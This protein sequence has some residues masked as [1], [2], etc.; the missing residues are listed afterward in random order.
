MAEAILRA[1]NLPG[2]NV[3]S[4]G[5]FTQD[6]IPMSEHAYKLV[7]E[8]HYPHTETSQMISKELI[9]WAD[10]VLTMTQGHRDQ[11]HQ[12]YPE[13]KAQIETLAAFI[14]MDKDIQDPYGGS[15]DLYEKTFNELTLYIERLYD[16]L[17]HDK[18]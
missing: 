6:G 1:K 17:K 10:Y 13:A 11:L 7:I 15:Y 5:I 16:Y 8:H 9:D 18:S 4:A 3:Q 2:V 12:L 14:G